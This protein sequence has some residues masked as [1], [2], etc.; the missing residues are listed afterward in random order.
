MGNSERNNLLKF[1]LA[2]RSNKESISSIRLDSLITDFME[3]VIEPKHERFQKISDVLGHFIP[4]GIYEHCRIDS[5]SEG[6]LN[7]YVDSPSYMYQ[8]QLYSA[9]ILSQLKRCCPQYHIKRLKTA[10]F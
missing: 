10:I 2:N 1:T 6:Q 9:D 7:I 8:L 5:I 3:N 4:S